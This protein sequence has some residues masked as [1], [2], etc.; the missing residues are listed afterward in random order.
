M[1]IDGLFHK[2]ILMLECLKAPFDKS[3][4]GDGV[5][6]R[7]YVQVSRELKCQATAIYGIIFFN[8]KKR[9]RQQI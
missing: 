8:L 7:P 6:K 9:L 4:F 1:A 3:G 5:E 2:T